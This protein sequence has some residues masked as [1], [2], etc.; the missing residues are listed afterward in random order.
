M[1]ELK[2]DWHGGV[3]QACGGDS[4]A[5]GARCP[6]RATN[7]LDLRRL[8]DVQ[9]RREKTR[10]RGQLAAGWAMAWVG[11]LLFTVGTARTWGWPGFIMW[12]GACLMLAAVCHYRGQM[13]DAE[14]GSANGS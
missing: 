5:P 14:E 1:G 13:A 3:C 6:G 7:V 8:E 2:H 9:S 4:S 12:I 11:W 10:G